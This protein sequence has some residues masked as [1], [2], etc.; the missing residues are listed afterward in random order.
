M[1]RSLGFFRV[2]WALLPEFP[3]AVAWALLPETRSL[4]TPKNKTGRRGVPILRKAPRLAHI[5]PW[6][7]PI[8]TTFATKACPPP[9]DW[10]GLRNS[11]SVEAPVRGASA[12]AAWR[13][14]YQR[15]ELVA[16]L[17]LRPGTR[18]A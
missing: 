8:Q 14:C 9:W 10:R 5:I 16:C 12:S 1:N 11:A 15:R 3:P 2:A 18:S 7:I 6:L 4:G 17:A 13:T